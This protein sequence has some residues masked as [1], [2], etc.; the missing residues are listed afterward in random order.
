MKVEI[1][2]I[3]FETSE[4]ASANK[5]Y[6]SSG[7]FM[8]EDKESGNNDLRFINKDV[9]HNFF[10]CPR[11]VFYGCVAVVQESEPLPIQEQQNK[12]D[13]DFILEFS[14]ILLNRK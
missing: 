3:E 5:N 11:S 9:S 10:I 8:V 12:F 1:K 13:G 7:L 2:S 4:L 6:P 14:R